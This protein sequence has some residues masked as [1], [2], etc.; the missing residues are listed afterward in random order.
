MLL[1][2]AVVGKTDWITTTDPDFQAPDTSFVERRT[3][4][5]AKNGIADGEIHFRI[6]VKAEI[7]QVMVCSYHVNNAI[8]A[9]E[10]TVDMNVPDARLEDYTPSNTRYPWTVRPEASVCGMLE[11]LPAGQHVLSLT[12]KE[13]PKSTGAVSHLIM[14]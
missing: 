12:S 6:N 11:N 1:S 9:T 14:W 5:H 7:P 2:D 8:T 10:F 3:G 13:G 4:Y